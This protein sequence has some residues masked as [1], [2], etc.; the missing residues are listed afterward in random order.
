MAI[1]DTYDDEIMVTLRQHTSPPSSSS[2]QDNSCGHIAPPRSYCCHEGDHQDLLEE[3]IMLIG[4]HYVLHDNDVGHDGDDDDGDDGD[5][6]D[7]EDGGGGG[8]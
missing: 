5:D 7:G 2:W 1:R 8:N 3:Y 6:E 4:E